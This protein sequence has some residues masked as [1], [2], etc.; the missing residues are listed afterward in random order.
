MQYAICNMKG[1]FVQ[2]AK[3]M[4]AVKI[5]P[6]QDKQSWFAEQEIYNLAQVVL[7]IVLHEKVQKLHLLFIKCY[8]SW[9]TTTSCSSLESTKEGRG[10]RC[11]TITIIITSTIIISTII[12]M[13]LVV[14]CQ[15]PGYPKYIL[16]YLILSQVEF[17]LVTSFHEHGSLCDFLKNNV[18]TVQVGKIIMT[19]LILNK[20]K[21]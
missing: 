17:W 5:F 21:K 6:L 10:S 3:E 12:M 1:I 16:S 11:K 20:T 14:S 9:A 2:V 8:C 15:Q 18:L 7:G 13:V 19:Q 4:V